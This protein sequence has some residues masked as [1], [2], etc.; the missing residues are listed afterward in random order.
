M[1]SNHMNSNHNADARLFAAFSTVAPMTPRM[2]LTMLAGLAE[3]EAEA[4]P[5]KAKAVTAD[6]N[7]TPRRVAHYGIFFPS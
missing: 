2:G 3:A 6:E 5:E 1:N 4:V 7:A